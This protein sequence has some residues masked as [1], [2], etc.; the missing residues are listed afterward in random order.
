MLRDDADPD[1]AWT[2][3]AKSRAPL[4]QLVMDQSVIAGLGN[5]YRTEI[6][7]RQH[8]HPEREGRS[9]AREAFDAF[10]ADAAALLRIG[11]EQRAILT[12]DGAT[13]GK[14]RYGERTN[15]FKKKTCPALRRRDPAVRDGGT[16]GVLLRRVS[17]EGVSVQRCWFSK[18]S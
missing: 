11:V 12:V 2:R 4:G 13:R 10:W 18:A 7:W 14:T 17:G 6:L 9:L 15:I 3:I 8:L 5:I 1:R 16:Q